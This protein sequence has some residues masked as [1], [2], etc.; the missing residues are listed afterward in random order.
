[1]SNWRNLLLLLRKNIRISFKDSAN[2]VNGNFYVA[3]E[4]GQLG[5]DVLNVIKKNIPLDITEPLG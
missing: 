3:V 1:M 2:V 5:T 4:L